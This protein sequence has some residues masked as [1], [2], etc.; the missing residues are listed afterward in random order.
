MHLGCHLSVGRGFD[1]AVE[2]AHELGAENLQYFPK[3]P[4][5]FRLKAVDRE[6]CERASRA[7]REEGFLSVAHS[8]YVTNLSTPDEELAGITVASIAND[9]E[10][11]E[12]YGSP[13]VVVHCGRHMG[14]GEE[15]GIRR[16]VELLDRIH[17]HYGGPAKLLLENTAGQGTELGTRFQELAEI[18]SRLAEPERAGY[19][20]DTCH[21]FAAGV[22]DFRHWDRFLE[23]IQR[24]GFLDSVGL[25]HLNDS[26]FEAGSHR[27]RHAKLGQ[28]AIGKENLTRFLAEPLF[29]EIPFILETPVAD[30][31]EYGQ[32]MRFARE[33][34]AS[35]RT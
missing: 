26:R 34:V 13:Y 19:C 33:W 15:A 4:R 5:S 31:A 9:L 14:Q 12:A 3:N 25:F 1:K 35:A 16:M 20:V 10:I 2:R 28:G 32:E 6:A 8:P 11:A 23:E 18:R 24:D 7:A 21:A 29:Q 17:E 22:L 27:D 30:E